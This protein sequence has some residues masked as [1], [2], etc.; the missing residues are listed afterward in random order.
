MK[1]C[2]NSVP[3]QGK[4]QACLVPSLRRWE[5]Y[6]PYNFQPVGGLRPHPPVQ[7]IA[8]YTS[9][10]EKCT[11]IQSRSWNRDLGHG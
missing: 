3:A 7:D 4:Q 2:L 11:Q 5:V 8:W 1:V 9:M 10:C 6:I